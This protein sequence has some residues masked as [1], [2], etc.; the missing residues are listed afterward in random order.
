MAIE[1]RV[2]T[3]RLCYLPK[4]RRSGIVQSACIIFASSFGCCLSLSPFVVRV[5]LGPSN[6]EV[7]VDPLPGLSSPR[8]RYVSRSAVIAVQ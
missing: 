2:L 8:S 7:G 1:L 5:I 6:S 4:D 3:I